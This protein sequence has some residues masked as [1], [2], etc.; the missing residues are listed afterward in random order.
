MNN[1]TLV[2]TTFEKFMEEIHY[3]IFPEVLDDDLP[4]HFDHWLSVL[5]VANM[6]EW[7]ELYGRQQFLAGQSHA[8]NVLTK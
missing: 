2:D 7:A 8:I 5:D 3:Q 6:M 1:D 4:D